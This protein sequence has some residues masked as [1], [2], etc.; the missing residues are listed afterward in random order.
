MLTPWLSLNRTSP[1]I[2]VQSLCSEV[3]DDQ[4][5]L[6][7]VVDL[8][9]SGL[10]IQRP[11]RGRSGMYRAPDGSELDRLVQV[12]FELPEVDEIVWAKGEVCFDQLWRAPGLLAPVRTTGVRLLAAATRHLRM[13]RDYVHA[14]G[15]VAP[16][17]GGF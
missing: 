16:P 9:E 11:L 3:I 5:Q 4:D 13:L 12:E 6:A 1:R 15:P 10:R 2:R 8:S 7:L 14:Y 17:V